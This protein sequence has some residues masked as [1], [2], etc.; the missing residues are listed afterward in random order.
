MLEAQSRQRISR[1]VQTVRAVQAVIDLQSFNETWVYVTSPGNVCE[2]CLSHEAEVYHTGSG[3]AY[4]T[5]IDKFPDLIWE[6]DV[7][8]RPNLHYTLW[9]K[10]TCKCR[11]FRSDLALLQEN[12]PDKPVMETEQTLTESP[13]I[14]TPTE[15]NNPFMIDPET[16]SLSASEYGDFLTGLAG[17]SYISTSLIGALMNR[18]GKQVTKDE[19]LSYLKTVETDN[20]LWVKIEQLIKGQ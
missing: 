8:I 2:H 5:L 13:Q 10:D 3:E 18:R 15:T 1:I 7:L 11:I 16:T 17:L 14:K 20:M 12:T 4:M 19:I 9:S 6:S